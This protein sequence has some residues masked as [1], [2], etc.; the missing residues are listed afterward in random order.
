MLEPQVNQSVN[1]FSTG[2]ASTS[3]SRLDPMHEG[4]RVLELLKAAKRSQSD[5]ADA[6]GVSTAMVSKYVK[7]ETFRPGA[8][9][10]L[11]AGLRRLGINP[12][13]IRKTITLN[14]ERPE[15]L[16]PYV[17]NMTAEQLR[18]VLRILDADDGARHVLRIAIEE[19]L[20]PRAK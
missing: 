13:Q 16:R 19:R 2:R 1:Q 20:A 5:L 7:S 17:A 3:G 10:T 4:E 8:W 18:G 9:D 15:D 11:S 6:A 14:R 12:E